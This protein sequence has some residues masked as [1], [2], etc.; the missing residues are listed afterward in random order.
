MEVALAELGTAEIAGDRDN[1]RIVEYHQATT[2]KATDDET[3]WCAA[4]VG[5]CL[6]QGAVKPTGSALARSYLP[7]GQSCAERYGAVAVLSRG[8][9][10]LQ[11]HVG[12]L[13]DATPTAV[14]LLAGNQGNAVSLSRFERTRLLGLRWPHEADRAGCY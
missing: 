1:P 3:P 12:F 10:P 14:W 13:V 8:T 4:F 6:G 5:W 7:W 11:G 9:K 2:L